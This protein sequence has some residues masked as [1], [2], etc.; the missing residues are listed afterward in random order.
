MTF[1][2]E[3]WSGKRIE[4]RKK[5]TIKNI[6]VGIFHPEIQNFCLKFGVG[7]FE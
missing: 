4:R 7:I 5:K 1:S 6:E 2:R 3:V